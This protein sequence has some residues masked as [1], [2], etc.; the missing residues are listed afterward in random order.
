[1]MSK[2]INCGKELA[3][4]MIFCPACG[5][6][7]TAQKAS[8]SSEALTGEPVG[9]VAEDIGSAAPEKKPVQQEPVKQQAPEAQPDMQKGDPLSMA[10][11]T[12]L[13]AKVKNKINAKT[14]ALAVICLLVMIFGYVSNSI[15][16]HTIDLNKYTTVTFEGYDGYGTAD[17]EI[18]WKAIEERYGEYISLTKSAKEALGGWADYYEPVEAL[19]LF[20]D[21]S[22]DKWNKL[23]NGEDVSLSFGIDEEY[24]KALNCKLKFKDVSVKVDGLDAVASVDPFEK[25]SVSFSG[26][27][28]YGYMNMEYN[29]PVFSDYDFEVVDAYN[30]SNGDEIKV[31]FSSDVTKYVGSEGVV[32]SVTEKAYTVEGLGHYMA[33]LNE[34]P[35]KDV[36]TLSENSRL[37]VDKYVGGFSSAT[38]VESIKCLG[39]YFQFAKDASNRDHNYYGVVYKITG[40]IQPEE[41]VAAEAFANYVSVEYPNII[42]QGD[43]TASYS[44]DY[45]T[46]TESYYSKRVQYGDNYWDYHTYYFYG[47]TNLN[48]LKDYHVL[49]STDRYDY[50][51]AVE[52]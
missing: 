11:A 38:T 35:E 5:T 29:G 51:W 3:E 2:C 48:D 26:V 17:V 37:V 8:G 32:P 42:I 16:N 7:Q 20:V 41:D 4:D 34:L 24:G 22:L 50:E 46:L 31:V 13:A 21:C 44:Y 36:E 45:S 10:A 47:F 12:A 30:L 27:D 19:E 40:H 25:L 28:G 9:A 14:I 18:D 23:A 33:A 15:S 39:T 43:G 52:E 1:M 49:T 6:R